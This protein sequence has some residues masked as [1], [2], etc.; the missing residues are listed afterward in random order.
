MAI[1][2]YPELEVDGVFAYSSNCLECIEPEEAAS[3]LAEGALNLIDDPSKITRIIMEIKCDG[4][5]LDED[6]TNFDLRCM[7][8]FKAELYSE[9]GQLVDSATSEH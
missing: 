3:F 6:P 2:P 1:E 9:D 5:C 7:I 8:N 4:Q